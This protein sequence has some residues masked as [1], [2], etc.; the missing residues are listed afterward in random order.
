MAYSGRGEDWW[1]R[2]RG[3]LVG[4]GKGFFGGNWRGEIG[5]SGI[6][7]GEGKSGEEEDS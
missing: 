4:V 7:G 3:I 1:E 6:V 5:G 2:E